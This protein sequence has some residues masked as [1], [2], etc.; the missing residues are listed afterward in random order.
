MRE[1]KKERE[2]EREGGEGGGER[3]GSQ[4][5]SKTLLT[6][7]SRHKITKQKHIYNILEVTIKKH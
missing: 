2:R 6:N 7:V 1:R 3:K 4:A 5:I